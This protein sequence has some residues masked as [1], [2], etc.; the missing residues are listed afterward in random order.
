MKYLIIL[1]L[2]LV[3]CNVPPEHP[4]RFFGIRTD[5]SMYTQMFN[6]ELALINRPPINVDFI[7]FYSQSKSDGIYDGLCSKGSDGIKVSMVMPDTEFNLYTYYIYIHEIGHCYFNKPHK[8]G[9]YIMNPEPYLF[10][11]GDFLDET[12]RL[13]YILEMLN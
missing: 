13:Q 5:V 2:L 10:M 6:S 3:G 11:S 9:P 8:M 4:A 7:Q 12:K 1:S